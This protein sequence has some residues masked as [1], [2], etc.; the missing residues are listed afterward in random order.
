MALPINHILAPRP[1]PE[2]SGIENL[3]NMT[4]GQVRWVNVA[5]SLAIGQFTDDQIH[6]EVLSALE[7]GDE[8]H[9][10][11]PHPTN[12][13]I[14]KLQV[15]VSRNTA[16][17]ITNRDRAIAGLQR[18]GVLRAGSAWE[19]YR[20]RDVVTIHSEPHGAVLFGFDTETG[21]RFMPEDVQGVHPGRGWSIVSATEAVGLEL[22]FAVPALGT[23]E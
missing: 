5:G 20:A 12:K 13:D 7:P 18:L 23:S 2:L 11:V 4:S 10:L 1:N 22:S 6:P 19:D 16:D 3:A 15:T 9:F 8:M 14:E 17:T 21:K